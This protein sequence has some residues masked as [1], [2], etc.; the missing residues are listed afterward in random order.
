M[1]ASQYKSP[2]DHG[3]RRGQRSWS[4]E[5]DDG[6]IPSKTGYVLNDLKTRGV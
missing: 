3:I 4:S 2:M 1:P 6:I 5:P